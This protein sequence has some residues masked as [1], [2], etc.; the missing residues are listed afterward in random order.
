MLVLKA[1]RLVRPKK[2]FGDIH[3]FADYGFNKSHSVAYAKLACQMAYLK[4]YYPLEFYAAILDK[5]TSN[6]TKFPKIVSEM[7]QRGIKLLL[8]SINQSGT[9]FVPTAKTTSFAT[10]YD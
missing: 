8:P 4:V 7:K 2:F 10:E 6:D 3:K 1:I 9:A 5:A